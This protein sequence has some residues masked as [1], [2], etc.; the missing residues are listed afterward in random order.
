MNLYIEQR[1]LELV[2]KI[3]TDNLKNAGVT[4]YVFGSRATG[5]AVKY[6]DLDLAVDYSG[7]ELPFEIYTKLKNAFENSLLPYKVDIV[8]LNTI[9]EEF[10]NNIKNDLVKLKI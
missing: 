1:H 3:L 10:K 7:A 4:V 8:D 5:R 6:S 2:K 9:S